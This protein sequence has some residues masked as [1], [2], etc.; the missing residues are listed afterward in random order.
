MW[1]GIIAL[2]NDQAAVQMHYLAGNAQLAELSLPQIPVH[3][4]GGVP[5][6]LRI[7]QRMRLEPSQLEGVIR[8]MQVSRH[9]ALSLHCTFEIDGNYS[10][11]RTK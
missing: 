7:S 1:Q 8:R 4:M 5:P 6:P 2:K 3:G 11:H 10:Y 9:C